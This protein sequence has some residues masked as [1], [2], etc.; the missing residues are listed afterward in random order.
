L[1]L[2]SFADRFPAEMKQKVEKLAEELVA[3][4]ASELEG[5]IHEPEATGALRQSRKL[6]AGKNG[7]L[8]LGWTSPAAIGIDVGRIQSKT[9]RRELASGKKSKPF[10]R[11]LGSES[12]KEGFTRPAVEGLRLG[13]DRIVAEVSQEFNS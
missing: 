6:I 4:A 9:Y 8:R 5:L 3:K 12:A 13:W 7:A 1:P 2:S 10:S 11:L